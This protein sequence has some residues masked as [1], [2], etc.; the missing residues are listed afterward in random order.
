MT[1]TFGKQIIYG[2]FFNFSSKSMKITNKMLKAFH[3][4]SEIR[5][6]DVS[7]FLSLSLLILGVLGLG[8]QEFYHLSYTP[9]S[10]HHFHF[11]NI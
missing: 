1:K 2:K 6:K 5:G 7:S 9:S 4:R 8:R 10:N 3:L 11:Y